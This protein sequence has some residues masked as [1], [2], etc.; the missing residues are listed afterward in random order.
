MMPIDGTGYGRSYYWEWK[1]K[2]IA[3]DNDEACKHFFSHFPVVKIEYK[4][5]KNGDNGLKL[6]VKCSACDAKFKITEQAL[7]AKF[8]NFYGQ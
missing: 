5:P 8:L 2:N 4:T 1:A 3:L 6:R 7:K